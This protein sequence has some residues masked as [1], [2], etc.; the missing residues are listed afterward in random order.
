MTSLVTLE[1]VRVALRIGNVF[2]SP[3]EDHEDDSILEDIYI[4]AAS[5]AI[6]R[7]LKDQAETVIT[8][9]ADSPATSVGCPEDVKLAV[10]MLVGM[11]YREPDGDEAKLFS[12]GEL[13]FPV[14]AMLYGYRDPA[15]A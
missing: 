15:L 12:R 2:D 9:L 4:P 11:I 8:G 5:T 7:Y 1:E 13:P 10:I 14:T 3:M 6:I